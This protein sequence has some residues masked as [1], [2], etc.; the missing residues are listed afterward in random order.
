M[1]KLSTKSPKSKKKIVGKPEPLQVP[2][3]LYNEIET[4][5]IYSGREFNSGV[6]AMQTAE[7]VSESLWLLLQRLTTKK[8][9]SC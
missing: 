4:Q 6:D 9:R 5:A 7:T 8:A 3:W 1:K 2:A